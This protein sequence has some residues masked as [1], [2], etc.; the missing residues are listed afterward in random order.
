MSY[1]AVLDAKGFRSAI[2]FSVTETIDTK[3]VELVP[4]LEIIE[5]Y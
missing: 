1:L 5:V 4:F 3:I 2:Q